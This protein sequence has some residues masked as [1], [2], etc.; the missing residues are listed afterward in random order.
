MH[1]AHRRA[2]KPAR[3][4]P[5]QQP[6]TERQIAKALLEILPTLTPDTRPVP[7]WVLVGALEVM[8]RQHGIECT[9]DQLRDALGAF[10]GYADAPKLFART[11]RLRDAQAIMGHLERLKTAV[12]A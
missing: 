10:R 3:F 2:R 12:D 5:T 9:T 1:A 4:Y 8:V 6:E 11:V 7:F